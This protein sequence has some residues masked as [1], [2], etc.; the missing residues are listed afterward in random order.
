MNS[1]ITAISKRAR[2]NA[3]RNTVQ[4]LYEW[5]MTGKN[6]SEVIAE[7]E[8]NGQTLAKTDVEYFKLLIRGTTKYSTE[9]DSRISSLIDRPVNE[10]DAV[11][12]AILHIGCYELIY[13]LEIPW[14]IIV[15]ESIELAKTFGAEQSH[16]YINGI[17]DKVAKELRSTEISNA[18]QS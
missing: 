5:F 2:I 8:S 18:S 9:L 7:F 6:V 17:L 12:R 1:N 11:E 13:H 14:R 4:A 10:L 15:N 16:K 3:R